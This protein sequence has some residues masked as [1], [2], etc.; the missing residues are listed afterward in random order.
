MNGETR[1]GATTFFLKH[2]IDTGD[3]IMQC[4]IDI[5]PEDNAGTVHDKLMHLG[6]EMVLK[7]V[8]DIIAGNVQTEPQPDGEFTPAPKIFKEDCKIDWNNSSEHIHNHIRGLSPYPAAY[9][10]MTDENGKETDVKIFQSKISSNTDFT[11]DA[12]KKIEPG[13]VVIYKKQLY[14]GCSDGLIEILEL[15]PAGK[16]RM[17]AEAFLLGYHPV[18]FS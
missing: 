8:S 14:I 10:I 2:E 12:G 9:A 6:S 4:A 1:T 17:S 11:E 7:T 13:D 15:Q 18:N 16:K 5:A 3:M